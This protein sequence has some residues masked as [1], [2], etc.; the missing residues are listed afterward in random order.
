MQF[1]SVGDSE[2]ACD[3]TKEEQ[4]STPSDIDASDFDRQGVDDCTGVAVE[5]STHED[6]AQKSN[7]TSDSA[8]H[9]TT[10]FFE[11]SP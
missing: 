10:A 9:D 3:V 4:L 7:G 1:S 6:P 5:V 8:S 2:A 11:L